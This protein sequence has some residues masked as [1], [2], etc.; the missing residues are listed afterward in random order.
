MIRKKLAEFLVETI[1]LDKLS[2]KS[3]K[4]QVYCII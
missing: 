2:N 4:P 3:I 1:D